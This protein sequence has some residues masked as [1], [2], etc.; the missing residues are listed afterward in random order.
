MMLV[1]EGESG[2]LD[3]FH[4]PHL[5]LPPPMVWIAMRRDNAISPAKLIARHD[6]TLKRLGVSSNVFWIDP[7]R[8][9][10]ATL[11]VDHPPLHDAAT[12]SIVD[13]IDCGRLYSI[14]KSI[15]IANRP[16]VSNGRLT[17]D[18]TRFG[19]AQLVIDKAPRHLRFFAMELRERL[20]KMFAFHAYSFDWFPEALECLTSELLL[21]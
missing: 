9:S 7:W 16:A 2:W 4:A 3:S 13:D 10:F 6:A 18:P 17:V 1:S 11:C 20:A 5:T 8:V 19:V 21:N 14:L 12:N 15:R